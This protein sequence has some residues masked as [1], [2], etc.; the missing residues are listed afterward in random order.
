[1]SFAEALRQSRSAM[2]ATVAVMVVVVT[3]S[4]GIAMGARTPD[5]S[6]GQ[7]L[8]LLGASG[9]L[10][11]ADSLSAEMLASLTEMHP[12][13]TVASSEDLAIPPV[14]RQAYE[15]TEL[16]LAVRI[17]ECGLDWSLVAALGRV[18]SD[19]ADRDL[20]TRG[21]TLGAILGPRLDGSRGVPRIRDTDGGRLDGDTTWDRA[22]GPFQIIP[23][24]WHRFGTDSDGDQTSDPHNVFD[25]SLVAG[26]YLCDGQ[27]DLRTLLGQAEAL[28]RY[29]RSEPF[30]RAV[31]G[32]SLAYQAA[33]QQQSVPMER[34]ELVPLPPAQSV[35]LPSEAPPAPAQ[36]P[37]GAAKSPTSS[38]PRPDAP[39]S[40]VTPLPPPVE[41]SGPP[42]PEPTS[43]PT[44]DPRVK[45][46]STTIPDPRPTTTRPPPVTTDPQPTTTRP[47]PVTTDPQ[48][49]TR[50]VVS[51]PVGDPGGG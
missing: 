5:P 31:L 13:R 41:S 4:V 51:S 14:A 38:L 29:Q 48:P 18:I 3:V 16:V 23:V 15:R 42:A 8:A 43:T 49:T 24:V 33:D 30:V 1:M 36:L 32:W 35:V 6:S 26:R 46:P 28:F 40:I 45:P 22:A 44:P 21:R 27:A 50:A 39:R 11:R 12:A 25:A 17:S 2:L 20:D 7:P 10:P 37:E 47:P 9:V 34:E 19:H